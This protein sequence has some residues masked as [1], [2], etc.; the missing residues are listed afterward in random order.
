[1]NSRSLGQSH[2]FNPI[3]S[4]G[5]G[6]NLVGTFQSNHSRIG[7]PHQQQQSLLG[8]NPPGLLPLRPNLTQTSGF[9]G[10]SNTSGRSGNGKN[11]FFL[12]K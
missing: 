5:N 12:R 9:I 1:M 2:N 8:N 6:T 10:S 4:N 11:I 7:P 3:A